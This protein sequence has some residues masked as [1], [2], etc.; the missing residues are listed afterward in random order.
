MTC[1]GCGAECG[2]EARFCASCG[3]PLMAVD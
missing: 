2:D 1:P 3:R